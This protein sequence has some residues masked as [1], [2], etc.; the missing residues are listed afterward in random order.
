MS[1][2]LLCLIIILAPLF[3]SVIAGIFRNQIGRVGAH[4]VT[5]TGVSISLIL[6][7]Y[8]ASLVLSGSIDSLNTN[9]YT[10]ASGNDIFPYAFHIGLLIDPLT[11]VMLVIVT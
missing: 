3:G 2:Q 4:S 1:I 9:L 8:V 11:S 6:S 10:W 7:L 5:I